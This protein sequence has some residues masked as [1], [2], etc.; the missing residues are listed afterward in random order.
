VLGRSGYI[1]KSVNC[2]GSIKT[3]LRSS[4]MHKN[5]LLG[6]GHDFAVV[7]LG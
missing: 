4:A 3:A 7:S 6:S 1:N 2:N 5:E